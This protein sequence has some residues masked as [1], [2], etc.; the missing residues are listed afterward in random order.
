MINNGSTDSCGISVVSVDITDFNCDDFGNNTVVLSVTDVNGNTATQTAIVNVINTSPDTDFDG[1]K[2]NCDDDDD[3]DGVLDEDDN[4]PLQFN[5]DQADNDNDGEGNACDDDD[6]NDG[7]LDTDDNCQFTYN[8]G[9]ED[10]DNDGLGDVCDTVELN[11]SQALTPNGDG[12]ND[13]WMIYNIENYPNSKVYVFNR[14]GAEVFS[15]V[16]YRNNWDGYYKNN[17]TSLPEG[18]YFYQIDMDGNGN[19]D[20]QGWIFLTR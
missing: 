5:P 20:Q 8:P 19:V 13:T 2:D 15:A 14:W 7:V 4:C 12:T 10:R 1:I 17:S 16:N 3:N 9:Q 18:S 11:V 6:D